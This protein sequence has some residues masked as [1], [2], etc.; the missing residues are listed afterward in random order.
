MEVHFETPAGRK[1]F[2]ACYLLAC[3]GGR[4]TVRDKLGVVVK[5]Q[6]FPERYSLVD[7]K[8]DLDV[9]NPRDYPYLAYFADPTEWMILVRQPHCWRF[10]FPFPASQPEPTHEEMSEKILRF[11]GPVEDMEILNTIVYRIHHRIATEWR[12]GRVFLMGDAAH[13]I[14]PMW[15]LGLNTGILD[16]ISLPW[17]LAWSPAGLPTP[18]LDGYA[19]EQR[20][21]AAHGSGEMAEAA[22]AY[23]ARRTKDVK[24]MSGMAWGDAYTRSLLGVRLDL[25][26]TG[27]WSM[28]KS[29]AESPPVE[30]GDRAPDGLVHDGNGREIRL[31][32]LF[33]RTF[34]ALYFT[35]TRRRP[36]IPE[37][38]LP[39]LKHYA[40]SR[41]DAPLDSGLRE[42]ALFDSATG[43]ATGRLR[44]GH[45]GSGPP[46]RPHRGHRTDGASRRGGG[47]PVRTVLSSTGSGAGVTIS[48]TYDFR[49]AVILITG[50]GQRNWRGSC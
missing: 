36:H 35:D 15:A 46:G 25:K 5:G 16:A 40:V 34:V 28:V 31:H 9:Q 30:V 49:D 39:W 43:S 6:S 50:A 41:W 1:V 13:L 24:A 38:D 29:F 48:V 17:R 4:S 12:R 42:R 21:V 45:H 27:N 10:L 23:M 7:V 11:I 32:D 44:S 37:N 19:R 14:T 18:L 20:P 3:D 26:G 33:G 22:R 8:V 47:L 2:D